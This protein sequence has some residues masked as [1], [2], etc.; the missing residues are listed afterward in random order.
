MSKLSFAACTR[1]AIAIV[2]GLSQ[3]APSHARSGNLLRKKFSSPMPMRNNRRAKAT[4]D[5]TPKYQRFPYYWP[6]CRD[7]FVIK[8]QEECS[9]AIAT[10]GIK[11]GGKPWTGSSTT[12]PSGCSLQKN[13]DS[14][15]FNTGPTGQRRHDLA[16]VCKWTGKEAPPDWFR[17]S[18]E[19]VK[20]ERGVERTI[21]VKPEEWDYF[22]GFQ[23]SRK[24]GFSCPCNRGSECNGIETP[25]KHWHPPNPEKATFDCTLW[26]AAWLHAEDQCIQ[27][28]F[29]HISRDGISPRMRCEAVGAVY[30]G[31]HQA[32]W[33]NTG[34]AALRGLQSSPGHCNSMFD[35]SF[36]G[37]A[38]AHGARRN[39]PRGDGDVWTVLYNGG[40]S[41]ISDSESCIPAGYT[42]TG[43]QKTEPS[44]GPSLSSSHNPSSLPSETH[45]SLPSLV[46]SSSSFAPSGSPSLPTQN[47][48]LG[49]AQNKCN[50]KKDQCIYT[51]KKMVQQCIA[52]EGQFESD[53][54][55]TTS[56]TL[57]LAKDW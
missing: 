8:T 11:N 46:P 45:S 10:L 5:G 3:P 57:C 1:F 24:N 2:L 25:G 6:D 37:F 43:E 30:K 22:L 21:T 19:N 32:G 35:P 29:S 54:S 15:V 47:V 40:G 27:G 36:L 41:D 26:I 17:V 20:E 12:M 52:K 13:T 56:K 51:K 23:E 7:G 50:K 28:Y 55:Q 34:P 48:C 49:L 18:R 14:A 31:E 4:D 38:V 33:H 39:D 9:E 44:G 53:C 16:P 42:A